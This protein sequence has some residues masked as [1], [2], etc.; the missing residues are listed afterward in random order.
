MDTQL[1]ASMIDHAAL[2]PGMTDGDLEREILLAKKYKT[3]SICIKPYAVRRAAELLAGSG[4]KVC[5]V[6]G[7]PHGNSATSVKLA[8]T[9][10]AIAD[11]A[12]EIDAVINIGKANS[13]DWEY[14]RHELHALTECCHSQGKPIK[15]IFENTYLKNNAC[16]EILCMLCS[17]LGCDFVKTST[18]FDFTKDSQG[19]VKTLGATIEDCLLMRKCSTP[20]VQIKASGGIRSKADIEKFHRIGVTRFG[21]SSTEQILSE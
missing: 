17:E 7:F 8:E 2:A 19:T 18:G 11:G 3:A 1:I 6:I 10:Q 12:E 4:V 14:I 16:K 21:T 9:E 15:I 13:G 20:A 5:T